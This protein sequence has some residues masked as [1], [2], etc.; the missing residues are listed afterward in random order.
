MCNCSPKDYVKSQGV[1]E[2]K[3]AS[4][5]H[6]LYIYKKV[7]CKT[8]VDQVYLFYTIKRV[9]LTKTRPTKN[10]DGTSFVESSQR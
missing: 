3:H 10:S 9:H 1:N 8:L 6:L 5:N 4:K 2:Q 7:F